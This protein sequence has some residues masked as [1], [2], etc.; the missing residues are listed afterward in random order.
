MLRKILLFFLFI[1]FLFPVIISAQKLEIYV[2]DTHPAHFIDKSGKL[3]G[4]VY[5]I[6]KEI[7]KII[8]TNEK[9]NVVPWKRAYIYATQPDKKN[10]LLFSTTFSEERR[11]KFKWIGPVNVSEWIF[12]AR[13][14][15]KIK[16]NSLEDAKK[17]EKIGCYLGDAR[18]AFLR[19]Q[20]FENLDVVSDN[21]YNFKTLLAGRIDLWIASPVSARRYGGSEFNKIKPVYTVKKFGLFL[22]FHKNTSNKIFKKWQSAYNII[23][24]NGTMRRICKKW[25][26]PFPVYKIPHKK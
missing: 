8:G 11:N 4:F 7:Q 9:I 13:A 5:E 14:D 23:R 21:K 6:V 3:T 26:V 24:K 17:V 12:Y 19:K 1:N 18:E 25:G 2:E 22:T 10:V 20:G 15:S 16:I